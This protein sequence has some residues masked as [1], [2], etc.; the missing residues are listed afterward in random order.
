M[1]KTVRIADG[2]RTLKAIDASEFTSMIAPFDLEPVFAANQRGLKAAAEAQAHLFA[3]LTKVNTE[4]F[5]FVDRRLQRDREVAR[6]LAN[7]ATPQEAAELCARFAESAIHDYSEEAGVLARICAEDAR[8]AF[9][10]AKHQVETTL[11]TE[12]RSTSTAA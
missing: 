9:E 1:P 5:S 2:K 6:D 12:D 10:D 7:C 11:A 8:E 4:L 3:R